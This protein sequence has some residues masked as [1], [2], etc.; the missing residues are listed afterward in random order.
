[1][2]RETVLEAGDAIYCERPYFKASSGNHPKFTIALMAIPLLS[3]VYAG[4]L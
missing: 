2:I 4:V 3:A 1:M